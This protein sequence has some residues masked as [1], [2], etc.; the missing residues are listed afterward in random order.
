MSKPEPSQTEAIVNIPNALTMARL[1]LTF[2]VCGLV[3]AHAYFAAF[4]CFVIASGTDAIDGYVARALGQTSALGRQLDPLVDKIMVISILVHLLPVFES[5][6][7]PWIVTI[8]VTREFVVQALR[9]AVEGRGVAF[10]ARWSGK[11]KTLVQCL[12]I[13]GV[14]LGLAYPG[15]AWIAVARDACLYAAAALTAY[16]GVEYVLAGWRTMGAH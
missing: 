13:G 6:V 12:A 15:I 11:I 1:A 16:S 10:G 14:L 9:S 4:L 2:V 7:F 3:A 5:A 8:V